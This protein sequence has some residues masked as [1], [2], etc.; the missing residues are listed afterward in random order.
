MSKI[1]DCFMPLSL[2]VTFMQLG[3]S[4]LERDLGGG[5]LI[6]TTTL[7]D[8]G[9]KVRVGVHSPLTFSHSRECT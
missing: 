2:G 3:K 8:E 5:S 9:S 4:F 7:Q 1:N 6:S